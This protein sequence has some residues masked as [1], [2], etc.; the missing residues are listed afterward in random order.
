MP[1]SKPEAT[2]AQA[3]TRSNTKSKKVAAVST[4]KWFLVDARGKVLG[5]L[6][7]VV[8][9]LLRGKEKV[10][11]VPYLDKGDYV[12]IIN[13]SKIE[14][15]GQKEERKNYYRYSGYPGGLRTETLKTLRNRRPEMIIEHAVAGM[16]PKTKLGKAMIKKLF[17][18]AGDSHPHEAQ[19]VEK[20]EV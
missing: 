5:R 12:V 4:K 16:L 10:E 8:A 15:T 14:A 17:V 2:V 11:Y 13:A 20:V 19:K 9:T 1:K 18:Y 3:K 6:A 7:T